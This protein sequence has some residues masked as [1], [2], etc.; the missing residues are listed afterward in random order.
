MTEAEEKVLAIMRGRKWFREVSADVMQNLGANEQLGF[1]R[2]AKE[3]ADLQVGGAAEIEQPMSE[4]EAAE[5]DCKLIEFGK[6]LGK[7]WR[8]APA[9]WLYF[10][11]SVTVTQYRYLRSARVQ[12]RIAAEERAEQ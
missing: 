2:E 4:A 12:R 8:D 7:A 1:W 5:M 10:M 6:F 9:W 3:Q 11:Q